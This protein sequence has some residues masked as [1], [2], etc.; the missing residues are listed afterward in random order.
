MEGDVERKD[1]INDLWWMQLCLPKRGYAIDVSQGG[2]REGEERDMYMR[3]ESVA[4]SGG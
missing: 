2:E 1:R 4:T 3:M